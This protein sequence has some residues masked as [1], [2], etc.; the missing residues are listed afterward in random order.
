MVALELSMSAGGRR[1]NNIRA[2]PFTGQ[3]EKNGRAFLPH[4]PSGPGATPGWGPPRRHGPSGSV[5][6]PGQ[7]AAGGTIGGPTTGG[8]RPFG[9][10]IMLPNWGLKAAQS[11]FQRFRLDPP[12]WAQVPSTSNRPA[13]WAAK[14]IFARIH[15][16]AKRAPSAPPPG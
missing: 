7:L 6:L 11:L 13:P 12:M 16:L 3:V 5:N 2:G 14:K 4:F 10:K 15:V 1:P 9:G 8:G